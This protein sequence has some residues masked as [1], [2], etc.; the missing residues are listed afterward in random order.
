MKKLL[1]QYGRKFVKENPPDKK[2]L[3]I[4]YQLLFSWF[5]VK[6]IVMYESLHSECIMNILPK[7]Q[8]LKTLF[9]FLT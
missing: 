8:V 5:F 1:T 4:F 6:N 2:I 3:D 7:N 9:Y